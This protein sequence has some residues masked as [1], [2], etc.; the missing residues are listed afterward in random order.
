MCEKKGVAWP[1]AQQT[2]LHYEKKTTNILYIQVL[3]LPVAWMCFES[4][5]IFFFCVTRNKLTQNRAP[6]HDHL[7]V[8]GPWGLI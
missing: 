7:V 3:Q 8:A 5:N 6:L 2:F 1:V 4:F